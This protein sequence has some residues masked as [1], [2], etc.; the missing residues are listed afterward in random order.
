MNPKLFAQ[1]EVVNTLVRTVGVKPVVVLVPGRWDLSYGWIRI[2][3]DSSRAT[4]PS[5]AVTLYVD[6]VDHWRWNTLHH[7]MDDGQIGEHV[8][9]YHSNDADDPRVM[10]DL[11]DDDWVT[12]IQSDD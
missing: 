3:S 11:A 12:L 9:A 10:D 2:E 6:E 1:L 4:V 7:R 8:W 5:D